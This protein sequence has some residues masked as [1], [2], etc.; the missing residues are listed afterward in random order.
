[1]RGAHLNS[2]FWAQWFNPREGTWIDGGAEGKV[3]S[4]KIG[5][6]MLP[7]VPEATDWGLKLVYAGPIPADTAR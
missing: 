2:L 7:P 1:M 5:V 3:R 6:I 4:S